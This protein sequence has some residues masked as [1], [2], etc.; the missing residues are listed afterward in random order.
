MCFLEQVE[1]GLNARDNIGIIDIFGGY[2]LYSFSEI[3]YFFICMFVLTDFVEEYN[4]LMLELVLTFS[5]GY[6]TNI[7]LF[8]FAI[9]FSFIMIG[10][11]LSFFKIAKM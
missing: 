1:N 6:Q 4:D 7:M 2:F 11:A 8:D 10:R 5:V 3:F 9:R